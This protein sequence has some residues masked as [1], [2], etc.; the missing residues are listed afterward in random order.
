MKKRN[1]FVIANNTHFQMLRAAPVAAN[2][3]GMGRNRDHTHHH[4]TGVQVQVH[5]KVFSYPTIHP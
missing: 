1:K 5:I 3:N 4:G 2:G